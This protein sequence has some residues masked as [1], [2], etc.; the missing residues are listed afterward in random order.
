MSMKSLPDELLSL[1]HREEVPFGRLTT[2]GVGGLCRWLFEPEEAGQAATFVRVCHREGIPWRVLGGGSN[3]VVLGDM[4]MPVLR[5]RLAPQA[6][7][8]GAS[9]AAPASHGFIR[10]SEVAADMGLSGLEFASGIPGT[11]GG[12]LHMNAGAHGHELA[13]VLERITYLTPEGELVERAPLPGDF[14]YRASFLGSGHVALGLTVALAPGDPG[15][16]RALMA[17]HRRRRTT[18][19]PLGARNAGC[20]FR[21]PPGDS[22]GRLIEASGLKGLR[23]GDA[24]VSAVHANFLLNHGHATAEDFGRLMALV[25]ARVLEATGVDLEPEVEIW[26]GHTPT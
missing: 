9:L 14:S 17:E 3:L 8:Q 5:L 4:D 12:A 21:N 19:Q 25:R 23:V 11:T 15:T 24:E 7:R 16:I 1:P 2:L 10:L 26:G 18:T 22:A 6:V 13:D 20:V